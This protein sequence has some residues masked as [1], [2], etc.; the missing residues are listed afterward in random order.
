[1][2]VTGGV[3]T[4]DFEEALRAAA[5]VG[6]TQDQ[7]IGLAAPLDITWLGRIA[8][9]WDQVETALRQAF[10]RGR[11]AA[12]QALDDAID[13]AER[14]L[15]DAGKR[16]RDVQLAL[17]ERAQRYLSQLIHSAL[18]H[19]ESVLT[20]GGQDLP[21]ISIDVA[22][23]ISLTGSLKAS[24]TELVELTGAGQISVSATYGVPAS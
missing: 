5:A 2:I 21:L 1:M 13:Q 15:T 22:Q 19:V 8:E 10:L 7:L 11:D 23:S 3:T 6:S 24:F 16:A 14:L 20:V 12:E 4:P 9:V 17:L 18:R